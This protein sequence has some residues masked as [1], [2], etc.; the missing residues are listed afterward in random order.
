MCGQC[1]RD[2]VLAWMD[3]RPADLEA[4][5]EPVLSTFGLERTDCLRDSGV[6]C[7]ADEVATL[8]TNPV[9]HSDMEKELS[10]LDF[11]ELG[12]TPPL[13]LSFA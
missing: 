13:D 3:N 1:S 8:A 11:L 9:V 7:T 4:V 10:S 5:L 6:V 2:A 12:G